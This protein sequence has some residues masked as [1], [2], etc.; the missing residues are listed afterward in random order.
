MI[1]LALIAFIA[2]LGEGL[3]NSVNDPLG[4]QVKADYVL[5]PSA[6]GNMSF[7]TQTAL[8]FSWATLFRSVAIRSRRPMGNSRG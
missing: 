1:G 7:P 5:T 6:S 4:K 8:A 2:T 3:R